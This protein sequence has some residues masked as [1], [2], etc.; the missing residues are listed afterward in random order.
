MST[1]EQRRSRRQVK[2]LA[3]M[4][5][6]QTIAELGTCDRMHVG[7]VIIRRGRCISWGFNGAPPGRP[8]C[9]ENDHGW[10]DTGLV[11]P[12][13]T[14][15]GCRNATHAEAN[16]LAFAAREGISTD[17]A[18][19][20]TTLSPCLD[21]GRLII[22]AGIHRVVYLEQY[23]DDAGLKLLRSVHH[24]ETQLLPQDYHEQPVPI[25]H[26]HE[27]ATPGDD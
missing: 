7:C 6:A 5:V 21:C 13:D 26:P 8:H 20:Y 19:L 3:F 23:R 15:K 16:A 25:A 27:Q 10:K 14:E 17:E 9:D 12:G 24:I 1:Y 18:T 22:A 11:L 2:D 4:R